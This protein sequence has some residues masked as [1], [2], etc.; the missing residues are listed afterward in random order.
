MARLQRGAQRP[1]L[2]ESHGLG[3]RERLLRATDQIVEEDLPGGPPGRAVGEELEADRAREG[4]AGAGEGDQARQPPGAVQARREVGVLEPQAGGL[5]RELRGLETAGGGR[6]VDDGEAQ[7]RHL[8]AE[9]DVPPS[10]VA[11]HGLQRPVPAVGVTNG[12]ETFTGI[13][14]NDFH[15]LVALPTERVEEHHG[16]PGPGGVEPRCD[17]LRRVAE[18]GAKSPQGEDLV[19]PGEAVGLRH[20]RSRQVVVHLVPQEALPL[21][22]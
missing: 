8:G 3:L 12:D 5:R 9:E 15:Q 10:V 2:D 20:A 17:R 6:Q 21:G 22:A 11:S 13:V 14:E 18:G 7:R 19:V 16:E 4:L 1:T